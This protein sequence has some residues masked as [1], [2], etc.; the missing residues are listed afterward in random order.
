MD[1]IERRIRGRATR[2][3]LAGL[4]TAAL[5]LLPEAALGGERG[6]VGSEAGWGTCAALLTLPYAP[7]KLAF[8]AGGGVV[9]GLTWLFSMGDDDAAMAVWRPSLGGDYVVSPDH[10][11]GRRDLA[12]IGPL[13]STGSEVAAATP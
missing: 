7:L 2:N 13:A 11:T 1:R 4:L 8:A 5:L 6:D 10:L 12:F 3:T 9:G